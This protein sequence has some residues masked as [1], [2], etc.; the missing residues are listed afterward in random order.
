MGRPEHL[1]PGKTALYIYDWN[2]LC[3]ELNFAEGFGIVNIEYSA[4][5][6]LIHLSV[7]D[8][9]ERTRGQRP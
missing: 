4:Q 8:M 7:Q 9:R 5:K 2:R 1:S 3:Q 6:Q